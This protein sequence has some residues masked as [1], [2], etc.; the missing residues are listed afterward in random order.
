M[1]RTI[2]LLITSIVFLLFP[3]LATSQNYH[4]VTEQFYEYGM[5]KFANP[6]DFRFEEDGIIFGKD[7]LQVKLID[8]WKGKTFVNN[9]DFWGS[10]QIL[11]NGQVK[12]TW[13]RPV[14]GEGEE[15]A[16]VIAAV[17]EKWLSQ[18]GAC[19]AQYICA[20]KSAFGWNDYS[21][22][23]NQQGTTSTSYLGFIDGSQKMHID[24]LNQLED[25]IED[26]YNNPEIVLKI[27]I[28]N[29]YKGNAKSYLQ[30]Q[31]KLQIHGSIN[32]QK[33]P[34]IAEQLKFLRWPLDQKYSFERTYLLIKDE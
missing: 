3:F 24:I 25:V 31:E 16:D 19:L 21:V 33:S 11:I 2:K 29:Y 28:L 32:G 13:T 10:I 34:E 14:E 1:K 26:Q 4:D 23:V 12:E 17:V 20:P 5:E 27:K 6:E 8:P 9:L 22:F 7:T 18:F 15:E 30:T